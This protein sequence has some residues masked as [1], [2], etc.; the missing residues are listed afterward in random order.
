MPV[1]PVSEDC[2]YLNVWAPAKS[3][4]VRR[5]VM[6]WFYGGGFQKGSASTPLYWGDEL[7]KKG[8]V[9]VN[10]SYR[11]GALGFL[12][13]PELTAESSHDVSGNYGLLDAIAGLKW[14]RANITEFGGDQTT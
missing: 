14:V 3:A 6:V 8:V 13:H 7:A 4:T 5:P 9:I 12:V 10:V 11:V 2:L 1:E